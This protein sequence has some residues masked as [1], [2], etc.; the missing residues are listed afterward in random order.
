MRNRAKSLSQLSLEICIYCDSD[1]SDED[2]IKNQYRT[3]GIKIVDCDS[4][5]ALEN[6]L[7]ND[8]PWE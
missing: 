2:I 3:D 5:D 4:G 8:L 6:Q 7:I 1:I